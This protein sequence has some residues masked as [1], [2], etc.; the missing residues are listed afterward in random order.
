MAAA[1]QPGFSQVLHSGPAR[2]AKALT[3]SDT[4]TFPETRG[5]Y[6]GGAGDVTV[7]MSGDGGTV[8]FSAVPAGSVI[9]VC[10]TQLRSTSTD[11][12]LVVA[13]W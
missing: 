9:P 3:K 5:L 7:T 10:C 2:F 6:V 8:T 12:T 4:A 11:A 1:T 13:L